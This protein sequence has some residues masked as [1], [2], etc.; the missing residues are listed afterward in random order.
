MA[1]RFALLVAAAATAAFG[2]GVAHAT[3]PADVEVRDILNG[4]KCI[5]PRPSTQWPLN[6]SCLHRLIPPPF[7]IGAVA[8][9]AGGCAPS[10]RGPDGRARPPVQ[11]GVDPGA[12]EP[13]QVPVPGRGHSA[14]EPGGRPGRSGPGLAYRGGGRRGGRA[15]APPA[16]ASLGCPQAELDGGGR[17][18]TRPGVLGAAARPVSNQ[19]RPELAGPAPAGHH[20]D[21][22]HAP[23]NGAGRRL[24]GRSRTFCSFYPALLPSTELNTGYSTIATFSKVKS[25]NTNDALPHP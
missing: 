11:R 14:L 18:G 17:P 21:R 10:P 9:D 15:A 20:P 6:I 24:D 8:G 1:L 5:W 16:L 12:H 4:C 19:E 25:P 22:V 3:I 7:V 23:A 13:R 2:T